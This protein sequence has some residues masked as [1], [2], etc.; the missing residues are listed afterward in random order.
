ME[1]KSKNEH[2]RRTLEARS[3]YFYSL[4]GELTN[5]WITSDEEQ[6]QMDSLIRAINKYI[7]YLNK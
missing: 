2:E 7:N 1:N 5:W 3:N 4:R 6:K